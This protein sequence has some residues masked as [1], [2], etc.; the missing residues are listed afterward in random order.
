MNKLQGN[1]AARRPT[2]K[3]GGTRRNVTA[4]G[5]IG[6]LVLALSACA[7]GTPGGSTGPTTAAQTTSTTASDAQPTI[8]D[9][10]DWDIT[11]L[12]GD[13]P[14]KVA[15]ADG[16]GNNTWRKVVYGVFQQEAAKCPNIT[17]VTHTDGGGDN[18]KASSDITSLAAQGV[19]IIVSLPDTGDAILPAFRDAMT[20]GVT[21]ISYFNP[22]N[23]KAGVDFS[24]AVIADTHSYGRLMSQWVLD[25]V[26]DGGNAIV[27]GGTTGCTSCAAMYRGA[28]EI[29]TNSKITLQGGGDIVTDYNPQK[30]E[31]VVSGLITQYGSISAILSDYG[32][33][34]QAALG[35]FKSAGKPLPALALAAG[36]NSVYCNWWN[37]KNAGTD[38]QFAEW[39]GGTQIVRAALRRGLADYN[40]I[41]WN[42]PLNITLPRL[43]DTTTGL[44][45]PACRTDL[46]DD[47]DMFSGLSDDELRAAIG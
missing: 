14:L 4:A 31:Q 26:P 20:A 3:P 38:Q 22:M 11:K 44:Y 7:P 18:Q 40:N 25:N 35:A 24:D 30:A 17:F 19:N 29:F 5:I 2:T 27:L 45:P 47:T 39:A 32:V 16:N 23:G 41:A 34:A 36:Q 42:E 46:P 37:N 10:A 15:L 43:I 12:C 9:N 8:W 1:P 28:S 21:V 13:K 33:V 6:V